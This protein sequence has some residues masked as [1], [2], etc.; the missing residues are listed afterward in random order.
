M[1]P[2]FDHTGPMGN[3]PMTGRQ[4]GMCANAQP[5]TMFNRFG[6]PRRMGL[7]CGFKRNFCN[8]VNP[9]TTS[10]DTLNMRRKWLQDE[11]ASIDEQLKNKSE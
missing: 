5:N 7:G 6:L 4:I 3:G 8:Y 9:N 1:M 11:L 2:R 10:I